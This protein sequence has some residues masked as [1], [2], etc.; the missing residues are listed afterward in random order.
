MPRGLAVFLALIIIFAFAAGL[1]TLLIAEIVSGANYLAQVVPQHLD[2]LIKYIEEYI[3]AQI[4]PLYNQLAGMF[5]RLD[6]GQKI[7]SSIIFKM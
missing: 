5:N 6:V 1:V 3:T 4:I 7:Q 2:T